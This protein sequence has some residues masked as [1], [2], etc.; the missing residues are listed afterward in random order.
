MYINQSL[1]IESDDNNNIL[2]ISMFH[3]INGK[4]IHIHQTYKSKHNKE[5]K[6]YTNGILENLEK[7]TS[8]IKRIKDYFK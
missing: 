8:F 6:F 5:A 1:V 7:K 4:W 3:L 2:S